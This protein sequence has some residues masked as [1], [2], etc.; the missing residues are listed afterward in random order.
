MRLKNMPIL[1]L[2][3]VIGMIIMYFSFGGC[4]TF[5]TIRGNRDIITAEIDVNGDFEKIQVSGSAD[6]LYR[7]SPDVS[8]VV[9][10]DSNLINFVDLHISDNTLHI[11]TQSG[12]YTFTKLSVEV[13]APTINS[14]TII[15]SGDFKSP[16]RLIA[17]SF[18]TR[19]SGSGDI[20]VDI[21]TISF[22]AAISGSGDI[23]ATGTAVK[24]TVSIAGSGDFKGADLQT[25]N[26]I[27][28]ISGSGDASVHATVSL[29]AQILG[30][31]DIR[32]RG[33]PTTIEKVV[34]GSGD[35]R[36][37]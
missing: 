14:V 9:S 5:T 8:V 4:K 31:G 26:S 21:E 27:V 30:S 22:S 1:L 29:D 25:E 23:K 34:R 11:G 24:S 3:I 6:V 18:E 20:A 17:P 15:G 35:V 10:A 12:S 2:G 37:L 33:E 16:D 13:S 19:I 32:Y 7:I 28:K 36:K